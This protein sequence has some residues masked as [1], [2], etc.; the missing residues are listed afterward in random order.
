M[1]NEH[2]QNVKRHLEALA[3]KQR[4]IVLGTRGANW[5]EE[6]PIVDAME[7]AEREDGEETPSPE[8]QELSW[9][10]DISLGSTPLEMQAPPTPPPKPV[11]AEKPKAPKPSK[12][13]ASKPTPNMVE[14]RPFTAASPEQLE[15]LGMAPPMA[16]ESSDEG[17]GIDREE[18]AAQEDV[19]PLNQDERDAKKQKLEKIRQAKIRVRNRFHG[20]PEPKEQE[21]GEEAPPEPP[22]PQPRQSLPFILGHTQFNFGNDMPNIRETD[23]GL[24]PDDIAQAAAFAS[25]AAEVSFVMIIDTL[26]RL[27]MAMLKMQN[28]LNVIN[29]ALDRSFGH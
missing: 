19:Q 23:G 1:L 13:P 17:E 10:L 14:A 9:S 25:D 2:E 8:E 29:E 24:E 3:K 18:E 16:E 27:T 28:D 5:R 22:K 12:P 21:E 4:E 26:E 6:L 15:S 11:V 7:R 20:I